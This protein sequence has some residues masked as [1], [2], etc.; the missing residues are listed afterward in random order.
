[1]TAHVAHSEYGGDATCTRRV[2][3][4]E[5][6]LIAPASAPAL[7]PAPVSAPAADHAQASRG[8]QVEPRAQLSCR[9]LYLTPIGSW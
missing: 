2:A 3:R 1:M 5:E 6:H 4:L 7:A 8:A 9:L